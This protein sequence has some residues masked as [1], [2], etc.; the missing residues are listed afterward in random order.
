MSKE[1]Q[2]V[3]ISSKSW[4]LLRWV[5]FELNEKSYSD[6]IIL[7]SDSIQNTSKSL[8]KTLK[9]FDI[10]RHRIKTKTPDGGSTIK[11]DN[12]LKTILLRSDT[13]KL[14]NRLKPENNLSR[15]EVSGKPFQ[16]DLSKANN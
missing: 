16:I 10:Y 6:A 15:I 14:L 4:E 3:K 11:P 12:K 2:N 5:K 1:S 8:Q 13:Q 9:S 7:L